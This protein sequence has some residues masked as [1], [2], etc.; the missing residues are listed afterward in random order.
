MRFAP[1]RVTSET[2]PI[3]SANVSP[4][5][6]FWLLRSYS[7]PWVWRLIL[8]NAPNIPTWFD[9]WKRLWIGLNWRKYM[10]RRG[11]VRRRC[12]TLLQRRKRSNLAQGAPTR[13]STRERKGGNVIRDVCTHWSWR[14]SGWTTRFCSKKFNSRIFDVASLKLEMLHD[15]TTVF[16]KKNQLTR[17][18]KARSLIK[19]KF[20]S[21]LAF[22]Q[23]KR[24]DYARWS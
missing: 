10:G 7:L 1:S 2:I 14:V 13:L 24:L 20:K 19:Q 9:T 11:T 6:T 23:H 16:W 22:E 5:Q 4:S 21:I 3:S 18:F 15:R 8:P 12:S 17:P